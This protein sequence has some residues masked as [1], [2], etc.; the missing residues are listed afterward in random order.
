MRNWFTKDVY[1]GT[2]S[3]EATQIFGLMAVFYFCCMGRIH[4]PYT[5][6]AVG[7]T[8]E[9][10][11]QVGDGKSDQDNAGGYFMKKCSRGN[12]MVEGNGGSY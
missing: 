6:S 9:L 12:A 8:K 7:T 2:T 1:N 3:K 11:W 5:V 4:L 10:T